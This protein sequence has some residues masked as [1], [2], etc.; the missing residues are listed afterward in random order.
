[1][2]LGHGFISD[3]TDQGVGRQQAERHDD[4]VLESLQTILLLTC[5]DDED[6]D[7]GNGGG[8]SES[9]LD[10]GARG[11]QL[12]RNGVLRDVLVV[13]W[14]TIALQTE[15]ADPYPGAHVDLAVGW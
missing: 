6:E 7:R 12:W 13:R 5:V 11:V 3:Q 4:R 9:V 14:Q 2:D 15:G 8:S 10:G 1:V